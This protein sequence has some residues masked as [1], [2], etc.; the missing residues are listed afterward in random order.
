[1]NFLMSVRPE[2]SDF[3]LERANLR[4]HRVYFRLERAEYKP[5]RVDFWPKKADFGCER[6]NFG[7]ER[8]DFR[9][10][11]VDL[12]LLGVISGLKESDLGLRSLGG[13]GGHTDVR[14]DGRIFSRCGRSKL[15]NPFV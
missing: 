2:R 14:S 8:G 1:M 6:A 12:S 13:G 10:E 9:S 15:I 5:G 11:R 4:P 3:R 7:P